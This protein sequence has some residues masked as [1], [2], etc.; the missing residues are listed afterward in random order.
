[1]N[2]SAASPRPTVGER[3]ELDRYTVVGAERILY[4]QRIDGVVRI[5][6]RPASGP[7][8]SYLIETGLEQ[9]GYAALKAL[10]ADYVRQAARL[11][12]VPMASSVARQTLQLEAT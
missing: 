8:R 12:A 6:D 4:G 9:D 2:L 1:M 5:T 11:G 7:G 10:V 3:V